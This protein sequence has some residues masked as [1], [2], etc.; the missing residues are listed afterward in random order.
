M[1]K[2]VTMCGKRRRRARAKAAAGAEAAAAAAAK[3]N[4]DSAAQ[5]SADAAS[6]KAVAEDKA[7]AD[8]KN[9]ESQFDEQGKLI[10]SQAAK[11]TSLDEKLAGMG[12]STQAVNTIQNEV[13]QEVDE[14]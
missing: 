7:A 3:A 12:G 2:D 13:Y 1:V 8:A 11:I 4:A 10:E 6:A 14:G 9:L 5:A